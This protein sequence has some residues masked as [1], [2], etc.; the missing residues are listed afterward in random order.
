[1]IKLSDY[2]PTISRFIKS[3]QL[4][5]VYV[6]A[7][8]GRRPCKVGHALNLRHRH[9]LTQ[10]GHAEEITIEHVTW[11]PSA[12]TAAL[13]AEDIRHRLGVS[14]GRAGWYNIEPTAAIEVVRRTCALFPSRNLLEHAV[15]LAQ[16]AAAG[17]RIS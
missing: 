13:I 10:E 2:T 5:A 15:F 9:G 4:A 6:F 17:F 14:D 7:V 1:L 11:C 12:A 16:A 3:N 8:D